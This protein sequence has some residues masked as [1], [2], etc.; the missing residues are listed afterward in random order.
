MTVG[1]FACITVATRHGDDHH[2]FDDYQGLALRR[3]VLGGLLAFFVLAQAGVP[4]TGG[5]V[6]K[7]EV[8]AAAVDAREYGLAVIGVLA[9]VVAAFF[10]LRIVV[11]L[12]SKPD[13]D[14][15][16]A[17]GGLAVDGWSAVVLTVA[18]AATLFVGVLP[19]AWLD[20]AKDATFLL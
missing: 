17:D 14:A 5:F 19:G 16:P 8:F 7:L 1:A 13:T 2:D 3:P 11:S 10:Y 4:L 15:E 9:A 12:F 18:A 20:F 6:V